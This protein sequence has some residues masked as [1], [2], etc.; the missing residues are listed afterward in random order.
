MGDDKL[1][2]I[3]SWDGYFLPGR[4]P[5][6]EAA[7]SRTLDFMTNKRGLPSHAHEFLMK[8]AIMGGSEWRRYADLTESITTSDFPQL[9]G[10]I[11]DRQLLG[12]YRAVTPE[13][14]SYVPTGTMADFR[15][16]QLHKV[17]GNDT[18]LDRVAEKGE[19]PLAPMSEARYTRQV[20]KYGRQFDISWESLINDALGAMSDIEERF[21]E[22]ALLTEAWEATGLYC[23]AAGPNTGLFGAPIADV[24]LQ[25]VTNQGAL[26]LSITNLETTLALMAQQTDVNGR[27]LG[28]R[29]VHLV[30]APAREFRARQILT[31]AFV[32]QVDT[33][34]G[35]NAAAPTY[36]PLPT[37]NIMPQMGLKLHVDPNLPIMDLTGN[38][39]G[40]WYLFA[41]ARG[42]AAKACQMDFLRGHESPEIAMK[43][44]NKIASG[45]GAISPFE[46]DFDTDN[47]FYRVRH[48]LGG[49]RLDPRYAYAQV[50]AL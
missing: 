23:S 33:T 7:L 13:W 47:V 42:S 36:V 19:Y 27:P 29:G 8:D 18:R 41:E 37:S 10:Q 26:P 39:D 46:G 16:G 31:S 12:R 32:Q 35:A 34:G 28:I 44:S 6:T 30:V 43:A 1:Q 9:F 49:C 40:T 25:N 21:V 45:G 3:E 11:L 4:R 14:R 38:N 17:Q 20:F 5:L 48:C 24:D 15:V 2:L 22:A 50:S